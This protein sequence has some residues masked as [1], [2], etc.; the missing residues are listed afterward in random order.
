MAKVEIKID[1]D[2]AEKKLER[3]LVKAEMLRISLNRD[4]NTAIGIYSPPRAEYMRGVVY[5]ATGMILGAI[6]L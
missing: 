1:T 3:L 5:V 2:K 4:N 6:L